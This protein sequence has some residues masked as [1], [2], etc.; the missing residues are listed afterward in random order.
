V[1]ELSFESQRDSA[2][3]PRVVPKGTTL[4]NS[5]EMG[6]NPKGV[7][8][9]VLAYAGGATPLGLG[10]IRSLDPGLLV[11]SNPGLEDAIP[12][13]LGARPG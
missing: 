6:I 12:S 8:P 5:A 3:K 10:H 1:I 7:A 11:P 4:G 13:G 2:S 9:P